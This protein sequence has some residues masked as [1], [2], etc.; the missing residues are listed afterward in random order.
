MKILSYGYT[1]EA[2]RT[3]TRL[4]MESLR[5]KGDEGGSVK[6]REAGNPRTAI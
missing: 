3:G 4:S 2:G 1:G 6:V 5:V